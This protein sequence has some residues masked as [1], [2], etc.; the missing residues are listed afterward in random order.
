MSLHFIESTALQGDTLWLLYSTGVLHPQ[1]RLVSL[2]L[3][4]GQQE[5]ITIPSSGTIEQFCIL[6]GGAILIASSN[7]EIWQ[8]SSKKMTF[9]SQLPESPLPDLLERYGL[10]NH[11]TMHKVQESGMIKGLGCPLFHDRILI[12]TIEGQKVMLLTSSSVLEYHQASGTWKT[13]QLHHL[14]PKAMR[15]PAFYSNDGYFYQGTCLGEWG[16]DLKR[17][18]TK[19]GV[20]DT[21]YKGTQVTSVIRDPWNRHSALFSTGTW[22]MRLDKGGIYRAIEEWEPVFSGKAV[23]SMKSD[24]HDIIAAITDGVHRIPHGLSERYDY[25]DHRFYNGIGVVTDDRFGTFVLT[26]IYRSQMV[27]GSVPLFAEWGG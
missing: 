20:I 10:D 24:K 18:N 17:I 23:Y 4:I 9:V 15:M 8:Y 14:I 1:G 13:V 25:P 5:E 27:C 21:L 12:M 26:D 7:R 11:S 3:T 19:T 22:H 16:G 6:P 2:N